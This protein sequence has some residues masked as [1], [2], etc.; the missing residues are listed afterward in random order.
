V[1]KDMGCRHLVD[2]IGNN[3]QNQSIEI[4]C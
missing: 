2:V 3:Y 4:L 1:L